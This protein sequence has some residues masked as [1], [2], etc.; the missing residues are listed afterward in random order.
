[1]ADQTTQIKG[2]LTMTVEGKGDKRELVLRVPLAQANGTSSSGKSTTIA[3]SGG[4]VQI[5]GEPEGTYFSLNVN[6]KIPKDQR[7][8]EAAAA[9]K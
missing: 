2:K 5:P 3:S 7:Q 1:M 4:F 8:K 6:A 9:V